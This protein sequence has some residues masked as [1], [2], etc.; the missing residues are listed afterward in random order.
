M[1][2]LFPK[3]YSPY[4][5][6]TEGPRRNKLDRGN[7]SK[8]EF[9]LLADLDWTWT[10]KVDGTNIRVLWDGVRVTFGGRTDNA[11]LQAT[12][13]SVLD[14][15]FP[16]TLLE[17]QFGETPC[18]LFGEGYGAKI[19][20]GGGN[21]RPDQSFALFDVKVGDWWLRPEDICDV[22]AKIGID[23]V[24]EVGTFSVESAIRRVENGLLSRYGDFFAEGLVG[25]PPLGL[26]ARN[27]DRLLMKVKHVDF[28]SAVTA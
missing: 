15:M 5:R 3:V 14:E 17:Q 22:A 16:E 12:L 23:S 11:Q 4:N 7:W 2:L 25:R 20:K 1:S 9:E 6:F 28:C 21:Y 24:P 27:G 18:V 26:L 13:V 19:Q 10:E 8:P